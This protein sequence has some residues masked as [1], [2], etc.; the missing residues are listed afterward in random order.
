[1]E[2]KNYAKIALIY[3]YKTRDAEKWSIDP[4]R[5]DLA[6]QVDQPLAPHQCDFGKDLT[7]HMLRDFKEAGGIIRVIN[8]D[9]ELILPLSEHKVLVPV[10]QKLLQ[11]WELND[12]LN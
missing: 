11:E 9:E 7:A 1:M 8:S 5:I 12:L 4:N 6:Y 2:I 10:P 3:A